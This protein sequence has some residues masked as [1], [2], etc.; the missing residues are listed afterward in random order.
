MYVKYI[1]FYEIRISTLKLSDKCK[2]VHIANSLTEET[3]STNF[4][5]MDKKVAI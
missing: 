5:S 4:L 2:S 1:W 3:Q